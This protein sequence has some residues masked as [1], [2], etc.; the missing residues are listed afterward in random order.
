MLT[1]G[2]S[3]NG[4]KY[5]LLVDKLIRLLSQKGIKNI[6]LSAV[7]GPCLAVGLAIEFIV[8]LLLQIKFRYR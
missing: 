8:E 3:I 6:N 2:L 1:K 7:G 5:E 4:N